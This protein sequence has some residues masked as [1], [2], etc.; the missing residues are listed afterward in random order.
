MSVQWASL[1][2]GR[3]RVVVEGPS[4]GPTVLMIHGLS[5]PLEAWGPVAEVLVAAGVRTVR[6]DLYGRGYSG[7]DGTPLSCDVM[8]NQQVALLDHLDIPGPMDL[9]SLSNA[10]LIALWMARFYPERVRSLAFV[11]PSGLDARTMNAS[12]RMMGRWPF[13]PA[14]AWW[15]QKRLVRRMGEHAAHMPAHAPTGCGEAYAASVAAASSHP[16]FGHAV[17][18]HLAS[19]PSPALLDESLRLV[20]DTSLPVQALHF[21]AEGDASPAGVAV[22]ERGLSQ[23]QSET[24]EDCG[25]MGM[26]ERPAAVA[27]WWLGHR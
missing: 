23:M 5:Y 4:E 18:S 7:W 24:L 16:L 1:P 15:M 2:H 6:S 14:M 19:L 17:V 21:G 13:S 26:L 25:H 11:G 3:V 8:A 27:E 20:A 12:T 10:D 9:I 22:L